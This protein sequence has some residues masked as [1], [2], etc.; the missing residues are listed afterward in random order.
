[1]PGAAGR[2]WE[3]T[4][5][6]SRPGGSCGAWAES[7]SF[8]LWVCGGDIHRRLL[9][10]Q[11]ACSPAPPIPRGLQVRCHLSPL[12]APSPP[13]RTAV[14]QAGAACLAP[15][16]ANLGP[17]SR[18][19]TKADTLPQVCLVRCGERGRHGVGVQPCPGSWRPG[20]NS[21]WGL[22]LMNRSPTPRS[23]PMRA[24]GLPG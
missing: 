22:A 16:T 7:H 6:M 24:V 18:P 12:G 23:S 21:A 1:M 8:L 20:P 5:P 3:L 4:A 13:Q 10:G 15:L 17:E 11:E 2:M 14:W 19:R 9:S